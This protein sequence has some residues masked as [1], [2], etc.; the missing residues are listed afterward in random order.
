MEKNS[1]YICFVCKKKLIIGATY[2]SCVP[3]SIT[4][5]KEH[6]PKD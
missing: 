5:C 2:G 3:F 4:Y 6:C 1:G